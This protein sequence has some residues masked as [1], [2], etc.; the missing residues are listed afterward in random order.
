M[1]EIPYTSKLAHAEDGKAL[2]LDYSILA[3]TGNCEFEQYGVKITEKNSGE[4]AMAFN[5][6][7]S[8]T[9]GMFLDMTANYL[10]RQGQS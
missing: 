9:N 10:R 7:T 2:A 5:L 3:S 1:R 8:T 4:Q 6:T